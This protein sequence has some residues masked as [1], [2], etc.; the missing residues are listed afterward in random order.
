LDEPFT[1]IDP[2]SIEELHRILQRL[3]DEGLGIV[4]TDHNVRDTLAITDVVYLIYEGRVV[5]TG[6]PDALA[7]SPVARRFYLGERFR[8]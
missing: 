2:R 5:W 4:I 3:R 1:G 8:P 6:R 7:E